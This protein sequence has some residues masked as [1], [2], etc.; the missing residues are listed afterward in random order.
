MRLALAMVM[1]C[2]ACS[3]QDDFL[4]ERSPAQTAAGAVEVPMTSGTSVPAGAWGPAH[5]A[6]FVV[7]EGSGLAVYKVPLPVTAGDVI[8]SWSLDWD[9]EDDAH[10]ILAELVIESPKRFGALDVAVLEV[11]AGRGVPAHRVDVSVEPGASYSVW[12]EASCSGECAWSGNVL[13][14]PKPGTLEVFH[15]FITVE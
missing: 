13:N 4:S 8:K 7:L 10:D 14:D 2:S 9:N 5:N 11:N 3:T 1:V 6:D 12:F 15:L